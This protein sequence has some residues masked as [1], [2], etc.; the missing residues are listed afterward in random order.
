MDEIQYV[1]E[2]VHLEM[3]LSIP[4]NFAVHFYCAMSQLFYVVTLVVSKNTAFF[5]LIY[6]ILRI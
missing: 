2:A 6:K 5:Y 1:F 4:P 3:Y